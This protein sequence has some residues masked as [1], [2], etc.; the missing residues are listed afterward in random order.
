MH[1]RTY[2]DPERDVVSLKLC[3]SVFDKGDMYM[4]DMGS[5]VKDWIVYGVQVRNGVLTVL[6][7]PN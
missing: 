3:R 6:A 2:D 4:E 7:Y 5:Q 1:V